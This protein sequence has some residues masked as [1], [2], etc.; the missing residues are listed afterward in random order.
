MKYLSERQAPGVFRADSALFE[1]DF[2]GTPRETGRRAPSGGLVYTEYRIRKTQVT[3]QFLPFQNKL[4]IVE[5]FA[6]TGETQLK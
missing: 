1:E 2:M 4:R 6:I 5:P 3:Q